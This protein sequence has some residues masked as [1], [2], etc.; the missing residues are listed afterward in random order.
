MRTAMSMG[1]DHPPTELEKVLHLHKTCE[2]VNILLLGYEKALQFVNPFWAI[3]IEQKRRMLRHH[4]LLHVAHHP[5]QI[6]V[7]VI[8]GGWYPLYF[9]IINSTNE[10]GNKYGIEYGNEYDNKYNNECKDEHLHMCLKVYKYK[11]F[12]ECVNE[13]VNEVDYEYDN[14]YDNEYGYESHS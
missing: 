9:F 6:L 14:A 12:K 4:S 13:Y 3:G 11:Y 2:H 10:Y 7:G 8:V 1:R 5:H